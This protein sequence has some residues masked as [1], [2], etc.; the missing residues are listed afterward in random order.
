[1]RRS[2]P[3]MS[4]SSRVTVEGEIDGETGVEAADTL[5]D[6]LLAGK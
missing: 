3:A 2:P 6:R 1:M 5:I 4:R